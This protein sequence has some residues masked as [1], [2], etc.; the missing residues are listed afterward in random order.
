MDKEKKIE[1]KKGLKTVTKTTKEQYPF[2][3]YIPI[4]NL[5]IDPTVRS[6]DESPYVFERNV[7]SVELFNRLNVIIHVYK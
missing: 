1:Y 4:F 5:F 3:R 6:F 2:I 7:M